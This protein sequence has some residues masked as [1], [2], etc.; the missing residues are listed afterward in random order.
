VNSLTPQPLKPA[1]VAKGWIG[2]IPGAESVNGKKNS[3]VH[4]RN[5]KFLDRPI[6]K[7]NGCAV[8]ELEIT[9]KDAVV[10]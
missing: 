10:A 2:P 4:S 3:L 5:P 9:S 1:A 7:P 8:Y 6:C